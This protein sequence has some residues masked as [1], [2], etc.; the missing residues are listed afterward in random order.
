[1]ENH[2]VRRFCKRAPRP[3]RRRTPAADHR[4]RHW[5]MHCLMAIGFAAHAMV[6]GAVVPSGRHRADTGDIPGTSPRTTG[7]SLQRISSCRTTVTS[8][9]NSSSRARRRASAHRRAGRPTTR[10]PR[11]LQHRSSD[12]TRLLVRRP[13]DPA[14]F[15]GIAIVEWVNVT[16]GYDVEIH[17]AIRLGC[18]VPGVRAGGPVAGQL[19]PLQHR[20]VAPIPYDDVIQHLDAQQPAALHKLRRE[21]EVLPRGLWGPPRGDCARGRWRRPG[22]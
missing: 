20:G 11:S 1:M 22:R 15:N 12:K 18:S 6:A 8:S 13:T 9:R 19:S 16:N 5:A 3:L 2:D 4:I 21:G 14:K 7:R 10:R 17:W